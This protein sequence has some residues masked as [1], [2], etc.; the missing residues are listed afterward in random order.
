MLYL[1]NRTICRHILVYIRNRVALG[2]K[3]SCSP[4][5]AA[6]RLGPEG[7]GVVYIVFIESG[8]LQFFRRQVACKLMDDGTYHLHVGQ[9]FR[10]YLMLRNVPNQALC[11]QAQCLRLICT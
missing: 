8:L 9:F 6:C 3:V 10:T 4:R 1:Q 11:G 7:K 2:L 5:R